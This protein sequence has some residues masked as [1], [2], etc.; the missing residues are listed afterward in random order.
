M[1]LTWLIAVNVVRDGFQHGQG[2]FSSSSL[3]SVNFKHSLLSCS[4]KSTSAVVGDFAQ[5]RPMIESISASR[6]SG[7]YDE[8]LPAKNCE[9]GMKQNYYAGMGSVSFRDS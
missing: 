1:T 9:S 7:V 8:V 2:K 3:S 5:I 4:S 6:S